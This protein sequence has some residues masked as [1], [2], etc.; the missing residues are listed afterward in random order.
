LCTLP[1]SE[2]I[3][4]FIR[5][6]ALEGLDAFG[7]QQL[8]RFRAIELQDQIRLLET[9][10]H[11]ESFQNIQQLRDGLVT[12]EDIYAIV[13]DVMKASIYLDDDEIKSLDKWKAKIINT[14][15]C[16]LFEQGNNP[17]S[18]LVDTGF[19]FAF[20]T[21]KQKESMQHA[22]VICLDGTHGMNKY[23]YHLFTLI[24]RHPLAG[25]GYPIAFLI[26]EYKKSLTLM[27]WLD[28]LKQEHNEWCPDIFMVDDAGEEIKAI[29]EKFSDSTVLLCHFHVLRS[30]RRKLNYHSGTKVDN[31]KA[32]VWK[33]LWQLMKTEGWDDAEAKKQVI[34]AID[35]WRR[36]NIEAVNIFANYFERWWKPK[37]DKWMLKYTYMRGRPGRRLDSEVYLLIEVVLRD[38]EF[39]AFLDELKV[40]RMN[41]Q[42]H[43]QR[44]REIIGTT[45]INPNDIYSVGSGIWIVH[46]ITNNDIEYSVRRKD[47]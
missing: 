26:S 4:Q 7:I 41:P 32:I 34:E 8:L 43:Q 35:R 17:N 46:S 11:S 13:R 45:N 23:D 37:Y 30:W 27:K 33:D 42:R 47:L 2:N 9:D 18:N 12:K 39:S 29:E 38:L 31:H 3:R 21:K 24:I 36:F 14:G 10:Q 44:I 6:R 25:S 1:L 19:L 20:Q 40:G 16:C 15:G 5:Q 28:F 22:R